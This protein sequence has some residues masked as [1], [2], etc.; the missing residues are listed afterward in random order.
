[1]TQLG[2]R[3]LNARSLVLSVLLGLPEP[4]LPA[5]AIARLAELFGVAPG[6]MRTALSRMVA[7]GELA[8]VNGAYELHG[9]RLI[10][11]KAAQDIGR[12]P[13][14]DTWDGTWWLVT[15]LAPSRAL[16]ARR[17]FRASM[18]NARMGE[19][20]P[21]TWLRP[22]NLAGPGPLDSTVVVRGPLEGTDEQALVARLWDLD[23]IGRRGGE[24]L[25]ALADGA[26]ELASGRHQ[27]LPAA[28]LLSA[29]IVRHLRAE[30]LLPRQLTPPAWPINELR[31]RYADFDRAYGRVLS[32]A[33]S[34]PAPDV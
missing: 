33:L 1:V 19:L 20:R 30:P 13:P 8:A 6:T 2:V 17:D 26:A 34:K 16:A 29:T 4:R 22:A 31:D 10:A 3:P 12:R 32:D 24:L 15:V 7:S 9:E 18:A 11:R 25:T 27:S 5:A 21:D 23:A 28:T 14:G